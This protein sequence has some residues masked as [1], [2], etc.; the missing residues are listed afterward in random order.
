MEYI[1]SISS[2]LSAPAY[3]AIWAVVM[4]ALV[5]AR[6]IGKVY[7]VRSQIGGDRIFRTT[8]CRVL[9]III[10]QHVNCNANHLQRPRYA[11]TGCELLHHP[12]KR[13]VCRQLRILQTAKLV[14]KIGTCSAA[15]LSS[16]SLDQPRSQAIMASSASLRTVRIENIVLESD[17]C[18]NDPSKFPE[19]SSQFEVA[20]STMKGG[21]PCIQLLDSLLER[22]PGSS[23]EVTDS[24]F[25]KQASTTW[26]DTRPAEESDRARV[27]TPAFG[28]RSA[29]VKPASDQSGICRHC[30]KPTAARTYPVHS[31][32]QLSAD[33]KELDHVAYGYLLM[34]V[35]GS[36]R[37]IL[38]TA[39]TPSFVRAMLVLWRFHLN[40]SFHSKASVFTALGHFKF[41]GTPAKLQGDALA[42]IQ[43]ISAA[44]V[45]IYDYVLA[46]FQS[47]VQPRDAQVGDWIRTE[48]SKLENLTS[49]ATSTI[50]MDSAS[51]LQDKG[52]QGNNHSHGRQ[53]VNQFGKPGGRPGQPTRPGAVTGPQH[54]CNRCKRVTINKEHIASNC[55]AKLSA[56]G[57][58]LDPKTA[59]QRPGQP[60]SGPGTK[61][62]NAATLKKH[63]AFLAGLPNDVNVVT[64]H[65]PAVGPASAPST[66]ARAFPQC[67]ATNCPCV[68]FN[69]KPGFHCCRTCRL[70]SPC[71]LQQH[72]TPSWSE[73]PLTVVGPGGTA[74]P[75]ACSTPGCNCVSHTGDQGDTCCRSCVDS[76][77]CT[78]TWHQVPSSPS[79]SW[80][81]EVE[82]VTS[83]T[84]GPPP[85]AYAVTSTTQTHSPNRR[86]R[87]APTSMSSHRLTPTLG[88]EK[89]T[90]EPT[91]EPTHEPTQTPTPIPPATDDASDDISAQIQDEEN[92]IVG[93]PNETPFQHAQH[94]IDWIKANMYPGIE[95]DKQIQKIKAELIRDLQDA[96]VTSVIAGATS[97]VEETETNLPTSESQSSVSVSTTEDE[98]SPTEVDSPDG[99]QTGTDPTGAGATS[100]Q[101]MLPPAAS[102]CPTLG[103]SARMSANPGAPSCG[104]PFC[105]HCSTEA[106]AARTS[107]LNPDMVAKAV[108]LS[109]QEQKYIRELQQLTLSHQQSAEAAA[110]LSKSQAIMDEKQRI[111]AAKERHVDILLADTLTIQNKPATFAHSLSVQGAAVMN[112]KLVLSI[113]VTEGQLTGLRINIAPSDMAKTVDD[114]HTHCATQLQPRPTFDSCT[115]KD[116][117]ARRR[118]ACMSA[119]NKREPKCG[120]DRCL[121]CDKYSYDRKFK[122]TIRAHVTSLSPLDDLSSTAGTPTRCSR[123]LRTGHDYDD[124]L[125]RPRS[126]ETAEQEDG[127]IPGSYGRVTAAVKRTRTNASNPGDST[128]GTA[129]INLVRVEP[130]P[131][132][133]PTAKA[134]GYPTPAP[135]DR[136]IR[137]TVAQ[138]MQS[139][140]QSAT[141]A[142]R[143]WG[144][145]FEQVQLDHTFPPE[146][147]HDFD[148]P[149]EQRHAES[150][151]QVQEHEFNADQC[152]TSR[153]AL[154]DAL[155][156]TYPEV[157]RERSLSYVDSVLA[158][159]PFDAMY[160]CFVQRV[161]PP[162]MVAVN[163][164][165]QYSHEWAF[166]VIRMFGS[167][168]G[169]V[170][171]V[172]ELER[173]VVEHQFVIGKYDDDRPILHATDKFWDY[174]RRF[175]QILRAMCVD[176]Y[177]T[178]EQARVGPKEQPGPELTRSGRITWNFEVLD[179]VNLRRSPFLTDAYTSHPM[180]PEY[181]G[182]EPSEIDFLKQTDRN[183][184]QLTDERTRIRH[185]MLMAQARLD[186]ID[187]QG[188]AYTR[189]KTAI[190]VGPPRGSPF[191]EA[192]ATTAASLMPTVELMDAM[193]IRSTGSARSSNPSGEDSNPS[194]ATEH[195]LSDVFELKLTATKSP[196]YPKSCPC[197]NCFC[198][199][200]LDFGQHDL[201]PVCHDCRHNICNGADRKLFAHNTRFLPVHEYKLHNIP[202]YY[203]SSSL[204]LQHLAPFKD[205]QLRLKLVLLGLL[206]RGDGMR[207]NTITLPHP[208]WENAYRCT[209]HCLNGVWVGQDDDSRDKAERET[210][211]LVLEYITT[212]IQE[213][214]SAS[215]LPPKFLLTE[216]TLYNDAME[217]AITLQGSNTLLLNPG[218]ISVPVDA[219]RSGPTPASSSAYS[220]SPPTPVPNATS[221]ETGSNRSTVHENATAQ[222]MPCACILPVPVQTAILKASS[223]HFLLGEDIRAVLDY[224]ASSTCTCHLKFLPPPTVTSRD[225]PLT[226]NTDRVSYRTAPAQVAPDHAVPAHLLHHSDVFEQAHQT[227]PRIQ[228]TTDGVLR[229]EY[230]RSTG[231]YTLYDAHQPD[232]ANVA[233]IID[234][235]LTAPDVF[236][237]DITAAFHELQLAVPNV[238]T[239]DGT[240]VSE[241]HDDNSFTSPADYP[242]DT[243]DDMPE[244][245]A[246]FDT[247]DDNATN[248]VDEFSD[249]PALLYSDTES[250]S[251]S[252]TDDELG[253]SHCL[254]PRTHSSVSLITAFNSVSHYNRSTSY[255]QP[256]KSDYFAAIKHYNFSEPISDAEVNIIAEALESCAKRGMR[257]IHSVNTGDDDS[258]IVDSGAMVSVFKEGDNLDP[259]ERIQLNGFAGGQIRADGSCN[260]HLATT[261]GLK[262]RVKGHQVPGISNDILSL[263][264]LIKS[265]Y[266]F[267][268]DNASHVYLQSPNGDHI[269][270]EFTPD[271][272]FRIPVVRPDDSTQQHPAP[273]GA[274][275]GVST[276]NMIHK[277]SLDQ[278]QSMHNQNHWRQQQL[279]HQHLLNQVSKIEP[280]LLQSMQLHTAFPHPHYKRLQLTIRGS[281][282]AK[283]LPGRICPVTCPSC[284]HCK[285]KAHG[286]SSKTDRGLLS[287]HDDQ[288]NISAVAINTSPVISRCAH[289]NVMEVVGIDN[290]TPDDDEHEEPIDAA[291]PSTATDRLPPPI[292]TPLTS[293]S[294]VHGRPREDITGLRYGEQVSI[295]HKMYTTRIG[296]RPRYM[297]LAVDRA[298]NTIYKV[299]IVRKSDTEQ[300]MDRI[301]SVLGLNHLRYRCSVYSD[302]CGS[303]VG[304]RKSCN[305]FGINHVWMSPG[306]QSL[307]P[308]ESA[309]GYLMENVTTL[310]HFAGITDLTLEPY[311]A[312]YVIYGHFRLA[313]N[314]VRGH[315][316]PHELAGMGSP[317]IRLMRTF[318]EPCSTNKGSHLRKKVLDNENKNNRNRFGFF[319]G[320]DGLF[321]NIAC[322][323]HPATNSVAKVRFSNI[324][325]DVQAELM[326][327]PT[328]GAAAPVSA[329]VR[330]PRS[331]QP[332]QPP[333]TV[334]YR[335]NSE[336]G[337]VTGSTQESLLNGTMDF[338]VEL[339]N[340][341]P[342][343]GPLSS[344]PAHA[345][346]W[347]SMLPH[348]IPPLQEM[349]EGSTLN[350]DLTKNQPYETA[351]HSD[352]LASIDV[353]GPPDS[354]ESV[355]SAELIQALNDRRGFLGKRNLRKGTATTNTAWSRWDAQVAMVLA[356]VTVPKTTVLSL[357][358]GNSNGTPSFMS[359]DDDDNI[360]VQSVNLVSYSGT[361]PE[362]DLHTRV[363]LAHVL[364][365]NATKDMKWASALQDPILGPKARIAFDKEL[366]SLTA[367][368]LEPILASNHKLAAECMAKGTRCRAILDIKRDG[369]V[370][371]RIVKIGFLENV[372]DADGAHFCYYSAV[373][374]L[375]SVRMLLFR[376]NQC[377]DDF[378]TVDLDTAF[379]QS[380]PYK[381]GEFKYCWVK[382]PITKEIL[383]FKQYSC[384][385]GER[386]APKRWFTTITPCF[387]EMGFIQGSNEECIFYN[388][389]TGLKLLIYV[390]DLAIAGK[391]KDIEA[392]VSQ[393]RKRFKAKEVMWLTEAN[394]IDFVGMIIG[395]TAN[396]LWLSMESYIDK[397]IQNLDPE[398][399]G[400]SNR[401]QHTPITEAI[402]DTTAP[403]NA[404]RKKWYMTAC[405]C[406][407][408]LSSTAR[409]D[410]S[411]AYGRLAQHMST[412]S[413]GALK[414]ML[415]ALA[416]LNQHKDWCLSALIADT[417]YNE[418]WEMYSDSDFAGNTEEISKRR[419]CNGLLVTM[420]RAPVMWSATV[421]SVCFPHKDMIVAAADISSAAAE[422][423]AIGNASFQ[424]LGLSYEAEELGLQF[425]LPF[426]LQ[427]DNQAAL[428]FVYNTVQRSRLRHIDCRM[429]WV[430]AIR[431]QDIMTA[432]HV[433]SEL[434]LADLFTKILVT[435]RFQ[436]LRNRM[437]RRHSFSMAGAGGSAAS[438]G[439]V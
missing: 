56:D 145:Q 134:T 385:Y 74:V 217:M 110:F 358:A 188:A 173:L 387:R 104:R 141:T 406:L 27:P 320:Y 29:D 312:D 388:P 162:W 40:S 366:S 409:P 82:R 384:I 81:R 295:D 292:M 334:P 76:D 212:Y 314:R 405:G 153:S 222:H 11:A 313:G 52:V 99:D 163:G 12:A 260:K 348:D 78:D 432:V 180:R 280:D 435:D 24:I 200:L 270:V 434:N 210:A 339:A 431:N 28:N 322:I 196:L 206:R 337:K 376:S 344:T 236:P 430:K 367:S 356:E 168:L 84:L 272:M 202:S 189:G 25:L 411:Y 424:I 144:I 287:E 353:T 243:W 224:E 137:K 407:G 365:M 150:L 362:D 221:N 17:K 46:L 412:P 64:V 159:P 255:V 136:P 151:L 154:H 267:H 396:R 164:P 8:C 304:A 20:I 2:S 114:Y 377:G 101:S 169:R 249:L 342:L 262:L 116:Y 113:P 285:T 107:G 59:K 87:T 10:V 73:Q 62:V 121:C 381:D 271:N 378:A 111:V 305:K 392:F 71:T 190:L 263:G 67:A 161:K 70:G 100:D 351:D 194:T 179:R 315:M 26:C 143:D 275:D 7:E 167:S 219:W 318:G 413:E 311:A 16:G 135:P 158:L 326:Q 88:T 47:V 213:W 316:S 120:R 331:T 438:A 369:R 277:P 36:Y 414:V 238:G 112:N 382:N 328:Q 245:V 336:E 373:T 265:G 397:V 269:K 426:T 184:Q 389:K 324:T 214:S 335:H 403:L 404:E 347:E 193:S 115:V 259:T 394:P 237:A 379:L 127:V 156:D 171:S 95:Q 21:P 3:Q 246:N 390:D 122:A 123:C 361:L 321:S 261:T 201:H 176:N 13:V 5:A 350:L 125:F 398:S 283:I 257:F 234:I 133:A 198:P 309:I 209:I 31:Y 254:H 360:Q 131:T 199:A 90:Q 258:I 108:T 203:Y 229:V 296:G 152:S 44:N 399:M 349:A 140:L 130:V 216:R 117:Y 354:P 417:D 247:A 370:K 298:S 230:D 178:L 264:Q 33:S 439:G 252:D 291:V 386:S 400:M 317:S 374:R 415:K 332:T 175:T 75:A 38:C 427:V 375:S 43:Q 338:E 77:P 244:L 79:H 391:R 34:C 138:Q 289:F 308:A 39:G 323:L 284:I 30:S 41:S 293:S 15:N 191:R 303:M 436:Y 211:Y 310:L 53:K 68:S 124:C 355:A 330:N 250:D 228:S 72:P 55:Y 253:L 340:G 54:T 256:Q 22:E 281:S 395:K 273:D 299:D 420:K 286:L 142:V 58:L 301:I 232:D 106:R 132:S 61:T 146:H 223:G 186:V 329:T 128:A 197:L 103:W 57:K 51:T 266:E 341:P 129:S 166:A 149:Y 172:S 181:A 297:L 416:Y 241:L 183:L 429:E 352:D 306:D 325:W 418:L 208:I 69:G 80:L 300:A 402:D 290:H 231:V 4:A 410:I 346:N 126:S 147:L 35:K 187:V 248:D 18:D 294:D 421:S 333:I 357:L 383:L 242:A 92:H 49:L 48:A 195:L 215:Q 278:Q 93:D 23:S 139:D 14:T 177:C 220:P 226:N 239:V 91:Q 282:D 174:P 160:A 227:P 66:G 50:I 182:Y 268:A 148:K 428:A 42:L 205:Y 98:S 364:Q 118:I 302:N 63:K 279:N 204:A 102:T 276:I 274:D 85:P 319:L 345:A 119:G 423:Y 19:W 157:C 192:K 37:N 45:N 235:D 9:A 97:D 359:A 65:K 185:L 408:W 372:V 437:M 401:P 165:D 32:W 433:S 155:S 96:G 343:H 170:V 371:V 94:S 109:F 240:M 89:P 288:S 368:I 251:D 363:Q 422:I 60:N 419:S 327:L 393:L 225:T 218:P 6:G 207:V 307:N 233:T 1:I 380:D 83:T 425:P 105:G 86:S